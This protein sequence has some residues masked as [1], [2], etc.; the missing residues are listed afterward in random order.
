MRDIELRVSSGV[1]TT[2]LMGAS[3]MPQESVCVCLGWI[4]GVTALVD[5]ASGLAGGGSAG[6]KLGNSTCEMR[7]GTGCN[8]E[9]GLD[10]PGPLLVL[11]S[12]HSQRPRV[13]S[14][15]AVQIRLPA[16]RGTSTAT[17]ALREA[18]DPSTR[19]RTASGPPGGRP[20]RNGL[21][22]QGAKLLI[23]ISTCAAREPAD[24]RRPH[25]VSAVSKGSVS[26]QKGA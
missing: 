13:G 1:R 18:G 2:V 11:R 19:R 26:I 10:R 8:E 15:K 7:C 23:P 5:R 9:R 14:P 4:V 6:W 3:C 16:D 22:D 24:A 21:W 20:Q 17:A 25:S 12:E